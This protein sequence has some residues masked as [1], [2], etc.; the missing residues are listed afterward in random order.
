METGRG[1]RTL[2]GIG[3]ERPVIYSAELLVRIF[4]EKSIIFRVVCFLFGR[5]YMARL[6]MMMTTSTM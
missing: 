1:G 4:N 3:R 5:P 6:P 2:N